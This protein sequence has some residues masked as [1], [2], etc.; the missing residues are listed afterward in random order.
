M[1]SRGIGTS[2][3]AWAYNSSMD[4]LEKNMRCHI[5]YCAKQDLNNIKIDSRQA[6]WTLTLTDRLKIKP[7]FEKKQ[8]RTAL[9]RPF[10]KQFLYFDKIFNEAQ[11]RIPKFFPKGDSENLAICIP[12]KGRKG[13]FSSLIT[14]TTPD[15]H[16][17]EQSQCFP[18]RTYDNTQKPPPQFENIVILITYKPKGQFSA[19]ITDTT[20]DVQVQYNGQCFPFLY[21]A[22]G[23]HRREHT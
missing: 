18:L 16:V 3:D 8:I 6:K 22:E 10:F 15:L 14:D 2:R 4:V 5:D 19:L 13:M 21:Y 7:R 12:D 17:I 11:V 1:Y 23:R 9:F 20:P